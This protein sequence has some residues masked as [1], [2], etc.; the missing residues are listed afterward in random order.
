M[1]R[2]LRL[3]PIPV[4]NRCDN[5]F[6]MY[7]TADVDMY[8]TKDFFANARGCKQPHIV[9]PDDWNCNSKTIQ[10]NHLMPENKK[11]EKSYWMH[12]ISTLVLLLALAIFFY[13][14]RTMKPSTHYSRKR[15]IQGIADF[16]KP[17]SSSIYS[18]LNVKHMRFTRSTRSNLDF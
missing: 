15:L 11:S 5:L 13:G 3:R 1:K 9:H 14:W 12:V 10:I 17:Y 16:T 7:Q 8:G 18:S 2:N 4:Y 6:F